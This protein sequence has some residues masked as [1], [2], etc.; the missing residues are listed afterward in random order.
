MI[1][2]GAFLDD[3][4]FGLPPE[5]IE[6]ILD[7]PIP[8]ST[9]RIWRACRGRVFKSREYVAW[10]K[11][12]DATVMSNRQFPRETITGP[13]EI[14]IY[15]AR[16]GAN[17]DGDNRIKACLD[18]LQSREIIA[19]D[20]DCLKGRWEWVPTSEAPLGCRVHL[21]SLHGAASNA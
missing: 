2:P 11:E 12:C 6:I 20:R 4:P 13:F 21:K 5:S 10:L 14:C 18:F 7:L 16:N 1:V 19:N 15:L 17:G 3:R 8:I 9:N